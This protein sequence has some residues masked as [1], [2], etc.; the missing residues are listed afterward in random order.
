VSSGPR[1]IAGGDEQGFRLVRIEDG[2]RISH[3]LE[4]PD[5]CDSLGVERWR[6]FVINGKHLQT[7][8]GFFIKLALQQQEK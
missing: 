2:D 4:V 8:F 6:E 5:G 7:I 3:I 1:I